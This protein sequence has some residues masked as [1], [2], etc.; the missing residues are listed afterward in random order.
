MAMPTRS[1]NFQGVSVMAQGMLVEFNLA[2]YAGW[3]FLSS[4]GS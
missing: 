2:R 3:M 1:P 4:I